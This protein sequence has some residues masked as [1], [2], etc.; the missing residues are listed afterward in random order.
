MISPRN[1]MLFVV[2]RCI[3]LRVVILLKPLK[4]CYQTRDVLV[5]A[6]SKI[7]TSIKLTRLML[8]KYLILSFLKQFWS[9]WDTK[10]KFIKTV[11]F[12]CSDECVW[13]T[14]FFCQWNLQL[15]ASSLL[16][17]VVPDSNA[18]QHGGHLVYICGMATSELSFSCLR[19]TYILHPSDF[20][21]TSLCWSRHYF[22]HNTHLQSCSSPKSTL[23]SSM[24]TVSMWLLL[25]ECGTSCCGFPYSCGMYSSYSWAS[26]FLL[27]FSVKPNYVCIREPL[28]LWVMLWFLLGPVK[29][30]CSQGFHVLLYTGISLFITESSSERSNLSP[31]VRERELILFF[32]G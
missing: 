29:K 22:I 32:L 11:S 31:V 23:D 3:L 1:V 28:K 2:V 15:L 5:L 17:C 21:G 9:T 8:V 10:G 6:P 19:S 16:K 27:A 12:K 30:K 13:L 18:N 4:C 20:L 14:R 25:F 26:I 24:Y 7:N